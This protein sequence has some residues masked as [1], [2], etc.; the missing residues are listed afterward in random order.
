MN[1]QWQPKKYL[2]TLLKVIGWISLSVIGLLILVALAIQV[3]YIQ[4]KLTQKAVSFLKGKIGTEVTLEHISLSIPKKIV[5]TGLYVED[6]QQDTLLYA[7]KLGIDTDLWAL[8]QRS[9]EL[10]NIELS[11]VTGN[12]TR[13]E[14]D[15]AFNFNFIVTAFATDTT[16]VP[17][18]TQAPW[19]FSIGDISLNKINVFFNDRLMGNEIALQLGALALSLEEFDLENSVIK[20]DNIDLENVIISVI[21]N[22]VAADTVDV[23]PDSSTSSSSFD[24]GVN[25]I[26]L[27]NIQARYHH[28]AKGQK[29]ALTLGELDLDA[30]HID[31]KNQLIDVKTFSLQ[32]TFISYHQMAGYEKAPKTESQPSKTPS[33]PWKISVKELNLADNSIQYHNFDKPLQREAFDT[34]H[35]WITKLNTQASNM[36]WEGEN[37]NAELSNLSFYE[38]SGFVIESLSTAFLMTKNSIELDNFKF[39]S[40]N[41]NIALNAETEFSSLQTLSE[42]YPDAAINLN[43]QKSI[44]G[45]RDIR[46]F[47]PAIFDSL[48]LKIARNT[49][50]Q[51]DTEIH[52]HLKDLSINHLDLQALSNT[53]LSVKG[54]IALRKDRDPFFDMQLEKFY[55]TKSD[56]KSILVDSLIP[57]TLALSEWINIRGNVKGDMNSPNVKTILTSSFGEIDLDAELHRDTFSNLSEYKANVKL[58]DFN[59]GKL[60]KKESSMGPITLAVSVDGSGLKMEE[61]DTQVKLHVQSFLY[62]GYNY[63]DLMVDGKLKKYFF[64]GLA[65]LQDDNLNFKL[66]GDLDYNQ[67]VPKYQFT[68]ELKNADFKALNLSVRPLKARGT[69][70]IDLATSDFKVINGDLGIRKFAIFNGNDVYAVDSLLFASIDQEGQSEI[71]IRSDILDGNFEGTINLYSLSEVIRRHFNNYFSLHDTAYKKPAQPQN[72]KFDLSI[73]NTD[74]LTEIIIPELDPFVPGIIRGEFDSNEDKLNLSVA[75]AKIRYAGIGSDSITFDVTSDKKKLAY[76]LSLR[77]ILID[78]LHIEALKLQG[79]VANDSIRTKL[80]ILDSLQKDKYVLGGVFHSLEKVFQFRFLQNEVVMN[81]APWTTPPD[82]SLQFTAKGIQAHNFSIT[83]INEM[84]ALKTSNDQDSVVSIVFKDLN[85]QNITKLVEGTTPVDGLANG[86]LNMMAAEEGAFNSTLRIDNLKILNQQ[87][88][89]LSLALGKTSSGPLNIDLA[90]NGEKTSLEADGYLSSNLTPSE[91]NFEARILKLDLATIE[92]LT[93]GKLKNTKGNVTGQ[94][95]I[96]GITSNP[97]IEGQLNFNKVS[98]T[99]SII[100]SE[101]TLDDEKITIEDGQIILTAFELK[102]NQ[103]NVAKLDGKITTEAFSNFDL[104]LKLSAK[105]FQVLNSTEKDNELFYGNVKVTTQANITGSLDQPIVDMNINLSDESNFTYVVPQSE[106]GVLE[107]KGIVEFIDRDAKKD[108]FLASINTRDTIKSTFKG[109]DISANIELNDNETLNIII[110]PATGDKLS[111]KG[112]STLTFDH[113]PTGDMTLTGRYEITEGSYD[114]SFY[115]LVKRKFEIE[116]GSTIIWSGNPLDATLNI[117]AIYEVETSAIELISNQTNDA[118]Q[119]NQYKQRLPFLVYLQIKGELLAPE[120]SFQLDLKESKRNAFGGSVYA[121]LRDINTRESELN[122]QVFA[123]L[124]LKRFISDNPLENRAGSDVTSTARRSVSKLLSEQLNRLSQNI[125]GVEL[126]FDVKS[127]EDYSSGSAEGQTQVQ[128]GL[129]KSLFDDRLVVKVAGNFEVEGETSNQ[130]S[131]SDYIGDLALEYKLTED[132]RFRITGFRNSNFDLISGELIETG[133]GLI[134]IKDYDTLRELFKANAKEK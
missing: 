118:Q 105:N 40:P 20:A 28:A 19:N 5:L 109:I 9:I 39:I 31:L 99:P 61:L 73:K 23:A 68:F 48:P 38:R 54:K 108:P 62:N 32:N 106:K 127:Y 70:D 85:L 89:N 124:I 66:E 96:S 13:S 77:D 114:L 119:L 131:V 130:N 8:T 11:D 123:L 83:N 107:Q 16:V 64:S 57:P 6:Q 12:V 52:G 71:S 110:D 125:K 117:R 97:D 22:K 65:E 44:I 46:F 92:P 1:F 126:S 17:D 76:T 15:S 14:R 132:G 133:V 49:T 36:N 18:T 104:N 81:Y 10:N 84:I 63:H 134:Y 103:N 101:F 111:V 113:D 122:K 34:N 59:I 3:P 79:N 112:N 4:N 86:D 37:M 2:I 72:F 56:I 53:S 93:G 74:L 58:K 29:L 69:L 116:K 35:L 27:K 47:A 95:A 24:F 43:I 120:I 128:L 80:V 21:Q 98:F 88:G 90:L 7:G 91:I 50:I 25:E 26:N 55:T 82:N 121:K 78:T 45:I 102:D 67:E 60:L 51:L 100:N 87:W 41:S 30:R 33:E 115:K 42:S 75:L 129:S 94:F